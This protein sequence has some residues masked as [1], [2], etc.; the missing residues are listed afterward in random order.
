MDSSPS[1]VSPSPRGLAIFDQPASSKPSTQLQSSSKENKP[2]STKQPTL[3]NSLAKKATTTTASEKDASGAEEV[4]TSPSPAAQSQPAAGKS[5]F[6][7]WLEQNRAQL[8]ADQP[9]MSEAELVR[10]AAQKFK[11][12]PEEER[13]VKKKKNKPCST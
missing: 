10:L 2:K 4:V 9:D 12:L 7:Q 6:Q 8:Q 11:T 13:Q 1:S 3:F 5:G